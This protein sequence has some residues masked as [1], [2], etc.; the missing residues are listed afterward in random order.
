M[1]FKAFLSISVFTLL[2]VFACATAPM[3]PDMTV[4]DLTAEYQA[5]KTKS[6]VDNFLIILDASLSMEDRDGE[7]VKFD[8]ARSFVQRMNQTLP[9]LR[10][11]WGR[12]LIYYY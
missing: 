9:P 8:L 4:R 10:G 11:R 3:M 2:A 6:K 7:Y 1:R 12:S 5:G